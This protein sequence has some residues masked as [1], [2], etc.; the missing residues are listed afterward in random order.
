MR[1]SSEQ[2][3][4]A[5]SSI[6]AIALTLLAGYVDAIG[7]LSL[8]HVYVANMSG[9]SIAIGIHTSKGQLSEV[10]RYAWP[11]MSFVAGLLL[12][13]LIV[14]WGMASGWRSVAAPAL[15][16]E[17]A[18]LAAFIAVPAGVF[19]VLLVAGAMGIQA[20]TVAR[21]RGLTVYTSFVTGSLVKLAEHG[22]ESIVEWLRKGDACPMYTANA[23]WFAS[24]W[25]AYVIGAIL[26]TAAL[27]ALARGS[28]IIAVA[29]VM[30]MVAID[31]IKPS[32][33]DTS[34][35]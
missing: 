29:Y 17:G 28:V 4:L 32:E 5:I 21:F 33:L 27:Q 16:L 30:V 1:A 10:W 6:L 31:L 13:R 24:I 15:L 9:N 25:V 35:T 2:R 23:L 18:A 8:G 26:G 34:I 11:V 12:S 7:Y 19:G 20:A 3:G 14:S 22:A